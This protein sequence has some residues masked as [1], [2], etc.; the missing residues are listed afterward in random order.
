MGSGL[1]GAAV[2]AGIQVDFTR[3]MNAILEVAP[4]A[5]WVRVQPGVVMGSLNRHL[6][7]Y[8]AFFAPDPSSENH[9]SLGGMIGTNAS[10]ARS[11]A[12]GGTKDHVL[13]LDLVMA[14]GSLF[15]ARPLELESRAETDLLGGTSFSSKAFASV[16]P[17]LRAGQET[18]RAGLPRVVKNSCGYRVETVLDE[19]PQGG[20]GRLAHLQR[21][22]VGA[23]GTL[24]LVTEATLN[25]VPLPAR[26]GIAMAYFPSIFASGEAV[27]GILALSPTAVEIMDSRFLAVVRRHDSRVDA[28]L[29]ERTDTALLIEFEGRD[30][31]ELAEKFGLS[32][33]ATSMRPPPSVWCG[34]RALPRPN[35]CGRCASRPWR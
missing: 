27:P 4:D 3:Y 21:L 16:L 34:R 10:G 1:N 19:G 29:P 2:G 31:Q 7:P 15:R 13:A 11:V 32:A 17:E 5:S 8:G 24:G 18:I 20:T 12:Y 25:L 6:L 23:E 14:D 30:E 33:S 35:I 28:M 22:F 26:R 9:C